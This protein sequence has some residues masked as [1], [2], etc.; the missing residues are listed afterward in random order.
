MN[1]NPGFKGAL[2]DAND[3]ADADTRYVAVDRVRANLQPIRDVFYGK[4]LIV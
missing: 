3:A 2:R 4:V 1:G